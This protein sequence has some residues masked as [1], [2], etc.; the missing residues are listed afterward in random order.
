MPLK[1]KS[2]ID[3]IKVSFGS[4]VDLEKLTTRCLM[5]LGYLALS[6]GFQQ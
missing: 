5:F 3:A 1:P 2:L 6:V 4:Q